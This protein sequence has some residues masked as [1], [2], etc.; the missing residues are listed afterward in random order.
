MIGRERQFALEKLAII[1][2]EY[3]NTLKERPIS[4][5]ERA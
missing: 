2:E 4:L 1:Q 3:P 5:E